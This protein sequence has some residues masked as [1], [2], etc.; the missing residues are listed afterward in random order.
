MPGLD[1]LAAARRIRAIEAET[2]GNRTP[3]MAL[4]ANAFAEDRAAALDA[5][6]DG[7]LVKPL[8][9][10]QLLKILAEIPG[11]APAPLAA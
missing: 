4:T 10:A 3:M 5:G 2:G 9:R 11:P 8:D 6:L 7:F 1:G